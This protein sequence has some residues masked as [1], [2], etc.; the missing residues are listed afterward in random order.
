[1]LMTCHTELIGV[2]VQRL[3][4]SDAVKLTHTLYII[5]GNINNVVYKKE[6]PTTLVN[7]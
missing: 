3:L 6:N 5:G 2:S 4:S 7:E 1:M